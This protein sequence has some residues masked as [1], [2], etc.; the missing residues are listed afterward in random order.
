MKELIKNEKG[1]VIKV[2]TQFPDKGRTQQHFKDQCDVN[3]IIKKYQQTG[4]LNHI[5]KT[6]GMYTDL[7][8]SSTYFEAMT[9]VVKAR[10]AF[11]TLPS[12]VRKEFGNKPEGLLDFINDPKNYDQALKWGLIEKDTRRAPE[13]VV[14]QPKGGQPENSK[15]TT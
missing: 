10:D 9:Q 12:A 4:H 7:P 11:E 13:P 6:Q 5:A 15:P 14:S 8:N 1:I 3:N 2:R